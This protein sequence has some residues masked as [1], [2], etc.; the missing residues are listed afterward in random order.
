MTSVVRILPLSM[1]RNI[2]FSL[3]TWHMKKNPT[4]QNKTT[5][6]YCICTGIYS[7]QSEEFVMFDKLCKLPH[8]DHV[9]STEQSRYIA[10]HVDTGLES[11]TDTHSKL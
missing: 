1:V 7:G 5:T 11:E 8:K 10:L 9:H 3:G 4:K 2:P 6:E